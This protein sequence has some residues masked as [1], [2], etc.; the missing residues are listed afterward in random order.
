MKKLFFII[1]A[2][3]FIA[4]LVFF[5]YASFFLK[6]QSDLPAVVIQNSGIEIF[7]LKANDVIYSPLK[8]SGVVNGGGWIGF[9][10]QVGVVRLFDDNGNE[11]ALGLLTAKGEWMQTKIDFETEL[12][13]IAPKTGTGKLVFYN[14]NPSGEPIRD[15]TFTLPVKFGK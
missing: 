1:C 8:I 3:L 5:F 15:K 6:K 10:A 2:I 7:S 14:E 13:F 4:I 9:E 12:N 11:L